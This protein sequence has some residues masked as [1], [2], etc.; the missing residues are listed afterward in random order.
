MDFR[1][2]LCRKALQY[3]TP[4]DYSLKQGDEVVSKG[5]DLTKL[6]IVDLNWALLAA[7]VKLGDKGSI[8]VWPIWSLK[9]VS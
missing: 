2:W 3:T 1:S 6:Y 8:V 5:W 7:A 9:K 4:I